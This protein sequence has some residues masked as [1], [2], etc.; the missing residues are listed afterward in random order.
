M[1]MVD[2]EH[3]V[4]NGLDL[5]P[6][7]CDFAGIQPPG[8]LMGRSVVPLTGGE[9]PSDWPDHIFL[10]TETG[11]MIHTGRYKY[12][13]DDI[14]K[15]REMFVDLK[16]DPGET[17]NLIDSPEYKNVIDSLRSELV[18]SLTMRGILFNKLLP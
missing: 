14:G 13:L 15:I 4:S 11:Y 10:E 16:T 6:T 17:K 7:L 3:L 1:G 18:N 8:G 5:L 12:E 9:K 2:N